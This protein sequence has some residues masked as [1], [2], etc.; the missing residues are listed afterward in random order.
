MGNW[1]TG[2]LSYYANGHCTMSCTGR[3][4]CDDS[5]SVFPTCDCLTGFTGDQCD[6]CQEGYFGSTCDLCP[7]GGGETKAAPR[8]TDTCGVAGSGRSRGTCDDGFT[9]SGNCTCFPN[10][11]GDDCRE[12]RKKIDLQKHNYSRR[13]PSFEDRESAARLSAS[14]S[15]RCRYSSSRS[16]RSSS[17][18][19][20]VE[21]AAGAHE[22]P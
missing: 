16:L 20:S 9:G 13:E 3:G 14:N 15:L 1:W 12:G 18:S 22:D 8:I 17:S 6:E 10:F 5:V 4:V 11:A 19:A 7:E 2:K 21:S